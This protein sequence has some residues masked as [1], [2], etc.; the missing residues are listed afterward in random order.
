[1]NDYTS[2]SVSLHTLKPSQFDPKWVLGVLVWSMSR[3][4]V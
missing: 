1:M 3:E 4:D 2:V